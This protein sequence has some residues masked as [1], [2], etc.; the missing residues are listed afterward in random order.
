MASLNPLVTVTVGWFMDCIGLVGLSGWWVCGCVRLPAW[1][2][3]FVAFGILACGSC[4]TT[5]LA[6]GSNSAASRPFGVLCGWVVALLRFRS[7]PFAAFDGG[8]ALLRPSASL[9]LVFALVSVDRLSMLRRSVVGRGWL[10][11]LACVLWRR[12]GL[13]VFALVAVDRLFMLVP[14]VCRCGSACGSA[15]Y[16]GWFRRLLVMGGWLVAWLHFHC[17]LGVAF[18]FGAAFVLVGRLLVAGLGVLLVAELGVGCWSLGLALSLALDVGSLQLRRCAGCS[19]SL[20]FHVLP[21]AT[22]STAT[23][24]QPLRPTLR[25]LSLRFAWCPM[26][27]HSSY[28]AGRF[29]LVGH[30]CPSPLVGCCVSRRSSVGRARRP[31]DVGTVSLWGPFWLVVGS[32]L[33][34][35]GLGVRR[36]AFW[37]TLDVVSVVGRRWVVG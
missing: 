21:E 2:L 22:S 11:L 15:F 20:R 4:S 35:A 19:V 32:W 6:Y 37:M 25:S 24:A 1:S 27:R 31:F 13:C 28:T 9:G 5:N 18:P 16:V 29:W 30:R 33:L 34:V 7:V 26:L 36:L 17:R 3:S 14:S 10:S 23:A 12:F 8:S